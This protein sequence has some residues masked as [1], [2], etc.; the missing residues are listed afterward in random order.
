[1]FVYI[2]I[3]SLSRQILLALGANLRALKLDRS[4]QSR[5]VHAEAS[6]I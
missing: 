3:H 5:F 2:Y 4:R 1:M 6:C